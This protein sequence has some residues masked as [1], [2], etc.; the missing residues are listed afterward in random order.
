MR[1][2]RG[3][4]VSA[5]MA[6]MLLGTGV[7]AGA[8]EAQTQAT[9][10]VTEAAEAETVSAEEA[11][12]LSAAIADAAS[13]V[14]P[15]SGLLAADVSA[16]QNYAEQSIQMIVGMTDEQIEEVIHPSSVLNVPQASV[17]AS[18]QSWEDVKGELGAFQN[19]VSHEVRVN[20]DALIVET[21]IACENQEGVVT[22]T[23]NR[24]TLGMDSMVFS[25]G[26]KTFGETMKEAGLNTLM[27]I[28]I[29]FCTLVFLSFLISRFKYIA[30]LEDALKNKKE[31]PKAAPAQVPAQTAPTAAPVVE[32]VVDD[33]ELI[34]VIAAAIA[35]A[36]GTS[37]DGFVVRSIRKSNRNKW[38]R[39]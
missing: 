12:E 11:A 9:E 33:G 20:D 3:F 31:A 32:E 27:G 35:A 21:V 34:A 26:E 28:G 16:L 30:K 39:A 8:E 7:T 19:I 6:A 4:F 2:F 25:T 15:K 37:T 17:V 36:E 13:S 1:K 29:V 38:Q 22:T 5:A 24:D 14:D 18:V 10:V 23:L